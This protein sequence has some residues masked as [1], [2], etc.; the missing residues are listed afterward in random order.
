MAK[1]PPP[2]PLLGIETEA[3]SSSSLSCYVV[4][5]SDYCQIGREVVVIFVVGSNLAYANGVSEI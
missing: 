2:P 3:G 5:L 4:H 1:N